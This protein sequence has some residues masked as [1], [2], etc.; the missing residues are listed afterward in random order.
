MSDNLT[1]P[2]WGH[3]YAPNHAPFNTYSKYP[4]P[5]FAYYVSSA[6]LPLF[7]LD[8]DLSLYLRIVLKVHPRAKHSVWACR[9]GG[10]VQKPVLLSVV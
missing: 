3:S 9:D 6:P 10:K 5:L 7:I 8:T 4:E 1:D 2:N